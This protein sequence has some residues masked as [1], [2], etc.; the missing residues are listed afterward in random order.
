MVGQAVGLPR[1][2]IAVERHGALTVEVHRDLVRVERV[3]HRRQRLAAVQIVGRVGA[4]AVHVDDEVGVVGEER[5]LPLGVTRVGAE[6]VGVD[7]LADRQPV[8]GLG[9]AHAS[10]T[11]R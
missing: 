7:E 10:V 4:L 1:R 9:R 11:W 5:L 8:R 6:R 2:A 3:E